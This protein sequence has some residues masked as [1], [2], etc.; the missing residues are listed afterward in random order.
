MLSRF[1]SLGV[2]TASTLHK[3]PNIRARIRANTDRRTPRITECSDVCNYGRLE[4][5]LEYSVRIRPVFPYS[6]WNTRE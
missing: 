4:I 2:N 3:E 6:T 5:H 1:S